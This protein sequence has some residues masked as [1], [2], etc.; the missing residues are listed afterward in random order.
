[1]ANPFKALAKLREARKLKQ[2]RQAD[3]TPRK[4]ETNKTGGSA[5]DNPANLK[6]STKQPGS[7]SSRTPTETAAVKARRM[8]AK[9]DALAEKRSLANAKKVAEEKA[10]ALKKATLKKAKDTGKKVDSALTSKKLKAE[11]AALA[12]KKRKNAQKEKKDQRNLFNTKGGKEG[13]E[14]LTGAKFK[15]QREARLKRNKAAS[16]KLDD[17]ISKSVGTKKKIIGGTALT[18]GVGVGGASLSRSGDKKSTTPTPTSA[19]TAA[20]KKAASEKRRAEGRQAFTDA[21]KRAAE[22]ARKRAATT[23]SDK[24]KTTPDLSLNKPKRA[25]VTGKDNSKGARNVGKGKALKANVTREQ[26]SKLGLDPSKKSSLTTY[27]NAYDKLGRRPTKKSDIAAKKNMGGM[28]KKKGYSM[29]GMSKKGYANG[30]PV[31]DTSGKVDSPRYRKSGE[32][33][34][35]KLMKDLEARGEKKVPRKGPTRQDRL[36]NATVKRKRPVK[37]LNP[38][39]INMN[40]EVRLQPDYPRPVSTAP[41]RKRPSDAP[42]RELQRTGPAPK[43]MMTRTPPNRVVANSMAKKGYANG[44]MTKSKGEKKV[45]RRGPTQQDRLS[46]A[47]VKRPDAYMQYQ[48]RDKPTAEVAR[49][50]KPRNVNSMAKKNMGGMMKKKGYSNGG[51]MR[52]KGFSAG[53]LATRGYGAIM[54]K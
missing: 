13:F 49:K 34:M 1:M 21:G 16:T 35:K 3:R 36:S 40:D 30:G 26:L 18:I 17:K 33:A 22:V 45:P 23:K 53:G 19:Q 9:K 48:P 38:K 54:K 6:S 47:T 15:K 4:V 46:N 43:E 20:Q 52:K 28:M 31:K 44:G 50:R 32:L 42:G 29:G 25:T 12:A 51:A 2:Q 11:K 39:K 14:K 41:R 7:S 37:Y 24:K 5:F 10:A 8:Q 27:L